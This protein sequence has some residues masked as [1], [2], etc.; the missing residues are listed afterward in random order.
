MKHYY[1]LRTGLILAGL[2][3]YYIAYNLNPSNPFSNFLFCTLE[4]AAPG[5][6]IVVL[7]FVL[8]IFSEYQVPVWSTI[9]LAISGL[10]L[11]IA[12]FI[13]GVSWLTRPTDTYFVCSHLL[14]STTLYP[15]GTSILHSATQFYNGSYWHG[16]WSC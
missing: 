10:V 6:I 8:D 12:T 4:M 15:N 11:V 13:I 2:S 9:V 1:E 14:T 3:M 16:T 7:A 5:L